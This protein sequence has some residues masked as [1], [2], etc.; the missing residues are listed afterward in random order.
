[1]FNMWT[2]GLMFWQMHSN[3]TKVRKDCRWFTHARVSVSPPFCLLFFQC[4]GV[5]RIAEVWRKMSLERGTQDWKRWQWF[6]GILGEHWIIYLGGRIKRW[7]LR[8]GLGDSR[9]GSVTEQ[10]ISWQALLNLDTTTEKVQL[11]ISCCNL[12]DI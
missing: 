8:W 3:L 11:K 5:V 4:R 1:M 9:D 2:A 6:A 12:T 7:R 10:G